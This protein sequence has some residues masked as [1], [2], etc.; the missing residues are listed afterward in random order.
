LPNLG[1]RTDL[2]ETPQR[3]QGAG[4][5]TPRGEGGAQ[6]SR[7]K[8]GFALGDELWVARRD[9]DQGMGWTWAWQFRPRRGP[10]VQQAA[11]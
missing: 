4:A 2:G 10:I 3:T 5:E 6:L 7:P 8:A 1:R 9:A 11:R